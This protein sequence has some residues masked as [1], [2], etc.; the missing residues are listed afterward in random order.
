M[1]HRTSKQTIAARPGS[2]PPCAAELLNGILAKGNQAKFLVALRQLTLDQG[3]IGGLARQAGFNRTQL[4]RTLS[5]RGNPDTRRLAA[6]LKA[7]G[8][9]LA[10][11]PLSKPKARTT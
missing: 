10:V 9:R 6:I 7:M 11:Q 4:Y 1:K 8:L 3:G 2:D 5:S